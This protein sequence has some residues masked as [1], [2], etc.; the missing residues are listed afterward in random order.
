MSINRH[1]NNVNRVRWAPL[2]NSQTLLLTGSKDQTV[3]LFDLRQAQH[4][5]ASWK[6][7]AEVTGL[8]WHPR[9]PNVFATTNADALLVYR[10]V[11]SHKVLLTKNANL[12]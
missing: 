4:E 9:S 6:D 8:V 3:K 11:H 7:S 12:P 5:L 1:N 10:H 2:Q